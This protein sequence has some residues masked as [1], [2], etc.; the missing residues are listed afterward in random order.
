MDGRLGIRV[1]GMAGIGMGMGRGGR[2]G[3]W[4]FTSRIHPVY[5]TA[6]RNPSACDVE[7]I[8]GSRELG[9]KEG[10]GG[11]SQKHSGDSMR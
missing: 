9:R 2:D 4:E 1:L 10:G 5:L 8:A 3:G 6:L 7:A 11:R